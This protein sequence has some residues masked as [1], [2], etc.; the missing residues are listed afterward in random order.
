MRREIRESGI[1]VDEVSAV[2]PV[3]VEH[4]ESGYDRSQQDKETVEKRVRCLVDI[5]GQ[6]CESCSFILVLLNAPA[7]NDYQAGE[8]EPE[9]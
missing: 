8:N 4:E 5:T 1:S 3:C 6:L 2:D 9:E 7:V